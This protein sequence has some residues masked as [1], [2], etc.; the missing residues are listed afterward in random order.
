LV[1]DTTWIHNYEGED[2]PATDDLLKPLLSA[3]FAEGRG[4]DPRR[5]VPSKSNGD[6][7]F[8]PWTETKR[9]F[10]KQV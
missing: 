7:R 1:F 8:R 2:Y 10:E 5:G 6:I 4:N 9:M 3:K